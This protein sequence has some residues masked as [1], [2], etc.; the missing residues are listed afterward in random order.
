MRVSSDLSP[1]RRGAVPL[2]LA[3]AV[4]TLLAAGTGP[5][6]ALC[7]YGTPHCVNPN[8]RPPL[9]AVGG[10]QI[11]DSGWQDPD[12]KYYHACGYTGLAT[13]QP[14]RTAPGTSAA[15]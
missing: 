3:G 2:A 12:C 5:A 13:G 7:K 6:F 1:R 10:V 11:P 4:F 15:W 9:P 8:P 14:A